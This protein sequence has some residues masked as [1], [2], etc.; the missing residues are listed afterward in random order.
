MIDLS[1]LR[2]GDRVC[3][4]IPERGGFSLGFG[5]V[6]KINIT[7]SRKSIDVIDRKF[8]GETKLKVNIKL[9]YKI[10]KKEDLINLSLK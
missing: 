10:I 4:K 6:E 9:I 1:N 5:D 2:V 3:F 8:P 7:R